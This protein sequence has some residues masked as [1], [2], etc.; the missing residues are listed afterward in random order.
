MFDRGKILLSYSKLTS[1]KDT[2]VIASTYPPLNTLTHAGVNNALG[3]CCLHPACSDIRL[4]PR[5][6]LQTFSILLLCKLGLTVNHQL[7]SEHAN[8]TENL[9]PVPMCL[10]ENRCDV[11]RFVCSSMASQMSCY[12]SAVAGPCGSA[13]AYNILLD[14][15][16]YQRNYS[17]LSYC[18][19][20]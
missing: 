19:F 15:V 13:A 8:R 5:P 12:Y 6:L 10:R 4:A 1:R 18:N 14:N 9:K 17:G 20:G 11:H 7:V 3:E 16:V 2:W